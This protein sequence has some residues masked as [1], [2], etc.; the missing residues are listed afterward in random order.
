MSQVF[1]ASAL[2]AA[3]VD[4][5][6]NGVWCASELRTDRVVVPHLAMFETASIIRRMEA[7][8]LVDRTTAS[9]ALADVRRLDAQYLPFEP[10]A[11]RA[12]ALRENLTVYDAAYVACAEIVGGR[13][14]TL[15]RRLA[16][17][18]GARCPV[19]VPDV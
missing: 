3:F 14:V 11:D 16:R 17:A 1:D 18:P 4:G 9:S 7:R 15:D 6:P 5:G 10:L 8:G 12:W 13:L 19:V 2:V